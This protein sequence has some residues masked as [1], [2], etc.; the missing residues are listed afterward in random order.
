MLKLGDRAFLHEAEKRM[1]GLLGALSGASPR[2]TYPLGFHH[3]AR[4]TAERLALVGDAA[5]GIHPIAGQGLNLGFRD[6]AA[7]AEVLVEGKRIGLDLGDPQLLARYQRWRGL[8]TFMVAWATDS[9]TRL[10]GVKGRAASAVRRFGISAVN[11]IPPLKDRFMAEA[12][13][14]SGALPKLLQGVA[15]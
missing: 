14:E 12:R 4:I 15:I 11:A 5:H 13:G 8:D 1:G 10:F 7:L 3:A 2:A 6:V 9:L